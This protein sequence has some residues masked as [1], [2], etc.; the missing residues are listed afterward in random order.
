MNDFQTGQGPS[1]IPEN[2]VEMDAQ[3]LRID[4]K[5]AFKNKQLARLLSD[6][7]VRSYLGEYQIKAL[8][9]LAAAYEGLTDASTGKYAGVFDNAAEMVLTDIQFIVNIARSSQGINVRTVKGRGPLEELRKR[10]P[11]WERY[12]PVPEK[13]NNNSPQGFQP[14]Y[15]PDYHNYQR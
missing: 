15:S 8:Y 14:N 10:E 2:Q 6:D 9:H 3:L 5:G 1:Y 12:K 7:L 13:Q 4:N 11:L